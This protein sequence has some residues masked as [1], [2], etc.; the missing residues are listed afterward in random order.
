MIVLRPSA[1]LALLLALPLATGCVGLFDPELYM[2][3]DAGDIER[4]A[5][6]I[7]L[8]GELAE[9]CGADAPLLRFP[10]GAQS[11][12]FDVDTR[13]RIDS[14]REVSGCTGRAQG[15][16]DLF[17]A[18]DATAREH[19]HFHIDVDPFEGRA[20]ADPAIYVLRDCDERACSEGDGL[21][22]CGAGSDEHFTFIPEENDRYVVAFDSPEGEGFEGRILSFRTVCG[23]GQRDHSENCDDG[24]TESG[25][26]CDALCRSELSA[27]R[28]MEVEVNDDIYAANF[29]GATP[30]DTITVRASLDTLCEVDVFAV[31]VPE[32]GGVE[33][34]LAGASGASC[35]IEL[36]EASVQLL[37][38]GVRGASERAR[39]TIATEDV[40]PSIGADATLAQDLPAGTYFVQLGVVRDRAD[41]VGYELALT[42]TE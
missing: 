37:E 39:A 34:S 17:M 2:S 36:A 35:P 25:D 16:P 3:A 11:A 30:G 5:E 8:E 15:G 18:I 10:A 27:S 38:L 26:G 7:G 22:L 9:L 23:D 31:D 42:V 29:V 19:W 20:A 14:T 4:D 33:V 6:V 24:N 12:T 21:D 41:S 1:P 32:G 40:C 28:P 13:G